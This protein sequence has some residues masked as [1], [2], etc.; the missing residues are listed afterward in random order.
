M[1]KLNISTKVG[2]DLK[3]FLHKSQFI[4]DEPVL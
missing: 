1:F 2:I 4:N 3:G